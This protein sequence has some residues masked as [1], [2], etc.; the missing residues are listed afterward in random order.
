MFPA[1]QLKAHLL[2]PTWMLD[3][4]PQTACQGLANHVPRCRIGVGLLPL[5]ST[6]E[7]AS[8]SGCY[9]S[10]PYDPRNVVMPASDGPGKRL[11]PSLYHMEISILH[12]LVESEIFG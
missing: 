3:D 6:P 12:Q 2:R 7:F 11:F 10:T 9:I 4:L 8:K 1:T 5:V